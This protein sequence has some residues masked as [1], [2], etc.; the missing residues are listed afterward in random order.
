M[1]F[2][3][4]GDPNTQTVNVT[5]EQLGYDANGDG[6]L[7]DTVTMP[8]FPPV[9]DNTAS[10]NQQWDVSFYTVKVYDTQVFD[11]A[12]GTHHMRF[13][14]G[15]YEYV[16]MIPLSGNLYLEV[17]DPD[18]NENPLMSELIHGQ[19]N[20]DSYSKDDNATGKGNEDSAPIWW[21]G[22]KASDRM[23]PEGALDD[24][25]N[26]PD[27]DVYL[28]IRGA[29][30]DPIN[31]ENSITGIMETVKIFVWNAQRGTWER[32][33]LKET[34]PNSGIFRSTTC[35][36]VAD[37]RHPGDGNLGSQPEDTI[38]SLIHISEPTRPY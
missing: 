5:E 1:N 19:W 30:D 38:L 28:G 29:G 18:Q 25:Q 10:R 34:A 37:A 36:L 26:E 6:D 4:D 2:L 33:D 11:G 3:G 13:L 21:R 16:D 27:D 7:A 14:N 32:M 31:Q 22:D 35:V 9:I 15:R 17:V 23:T 20:K 24:R 8:A 12:T